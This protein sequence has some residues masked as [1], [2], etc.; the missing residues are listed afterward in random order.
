MRNILRRLRSWKILRTEPPKQHRWVITLGSFDF[1]ST[2]KYFRY[3][4]EEVWGWTSSARYAQKFRSP[5][6]AEEAAQSCSLYYK[7]TYSIKQLY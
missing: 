6:L 2:N 3:E 4:W 7:Q 1:G 5:D